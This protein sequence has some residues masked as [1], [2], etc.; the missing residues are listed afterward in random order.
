MHKWVVQLLVGSVN[1]SIS[2]FEASS[3]HEDVGNLRWSITSLSRIHGFAQNFPPS[4]LV[5]LSAA[6][7]VETWAGNL[8]RYRGRDTILNQQTG[9]YFRFTTKHE[10]TI[11]LFNMG[12]HLS[13]IHTN[14]TITETLWAKVNMT[15]MRRLLEGSCWVQPSP[16]WSLIVRSE[17]SRTWIPCH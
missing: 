5:P 7:A 14:T 1:K 17:R 12:Y 3:C 6:G 16:R 10:R 11:F 15:C 8:F 9:G 13:Q 2:R 4:W